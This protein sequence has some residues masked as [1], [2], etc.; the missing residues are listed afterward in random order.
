MRLPRDL[1]GS[2]LVKKLGRYDQ[3]VRW[4]KPPLR[5]KWMDARAFAELPESIQVRELRVELKDQGGRKRRVTLVT[6]LLDERK[7]PAAQVAELYARRWRIEDAIRTLKHTLKLDV[8]RCKSVHGVLKEL[9][10]IVL[11]HNMVRMVMLEAARKQDATPD[12]IS[13]IDALRWWRWARPDEPLPVLVTN[14]LRPGRH[15]PRVRKRRAKAYPLMHQPRS[16][17]KAQTSKTA[18]R[19]AK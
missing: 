15:E 14:P 16:V 2:E 5:P 6:T 8:L 12:R 3:V 7:Y 17:L 1:T 9:F 19:C 11:V 10:A 13:F 18:S 4:L